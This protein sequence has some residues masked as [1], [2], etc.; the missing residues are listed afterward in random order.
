MQV[1]EIFSQ[2]SYGF[3]NSSEGRA[4]TIFMV[5]RE[6]VMTWPMRRR[7]AVLEE[8]LKD[9]DE[10]V[11]FGTPSFAQKRRKGW[12]IHVVA[13][14]KKPQV[15]RLV[16]RSRRTSLR[17][18]SVVGWG[19]LIPPFAHNHPTDEDL[20]VGAPVARKDGAPTLLRTGRKRR[21]FDSF[22]ARAKLR[23]G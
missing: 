23:S 5:S 8:K 20:S 2:G 3:G 1:Q 4:F 22:G 19:L 12:G 15:L 7:M 17:M 16:W 11:R 14:R 18:T 6:T 21:S 10:I 9:F 13:E